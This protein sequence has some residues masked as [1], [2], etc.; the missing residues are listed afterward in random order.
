[1]DAFVHTP[2]CFS[3]VFYGGQDRTHLSHKVDLNKMSFREPFLS[4]NF[5]LPDPVKEVG[6]VGWTRY[7]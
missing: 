7:A 2:C 4:M 3:V 1:M 5:F 6:L